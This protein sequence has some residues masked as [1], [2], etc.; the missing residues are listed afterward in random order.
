VVWFGKGSK[1]PVGRSQNVKRK[2]TG[3]LTGGLWRK[4]F[5][6]HVNL[7]QCPVRVLTYLKKEV[8][9]K[10][11]KGKGGPGLRKADR[12]VREEEKKRTLRGSDTHIVLAE[13]V[14]FKFLPDLKH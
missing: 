4:A 5:F 12:T 10:R 7:V 8:C 3:R 13:R 1:D 2:N 14:T 11:R 9:G 6:S